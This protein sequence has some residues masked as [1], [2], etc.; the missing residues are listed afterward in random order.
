MWEMYK[1]CLDKNNTC[2][3]MCYLQLREDKHKPRLNFLSWNPTREHK[4]PVLYC[5]TGIEMLNGNKNKRLTNEVNLEFIVFLHRSS[6]AKQ[7][8]CPLQN[9][10]YEPSTGHLPSPFPQDPEKSTPRSLSCSRKVCY[11][12]PWRLS[13]LQPS[14]PCSRNR[15]L[16]KNR[17]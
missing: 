2:S 10:L 6:L 13:S 9:H 5:L 1:S 11:A 17:C 8:P 7:I 15:L 16:Y 12:T 3:K 4:I 14:Y